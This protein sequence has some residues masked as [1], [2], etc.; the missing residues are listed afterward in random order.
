MS[1]HSTRLGLNWAACYVVVGAL[2]TLAPGVQAAVIVDDSW[3]DGG[4]NNGADPLDSNWWHSS[5]SNGIEVSTG[6]LG[7][8]TGTAGRG[9]HT[10]FP[11]QTLANAGDKLIA[12]YTFTT[13]QT[14]GSGG[15][16]FRV[17]L[18]DTLSRAGLDG[19]I[20]ASSGSPNSL[21][22]YHGTNTPGL[23][24]YMMDMDVRTSGTE[25]LNFR[26]HG[27]AVVAGSTPTGRLMGTTTGFTSISPS[28]PDG[29]YA[30][31]PNT[32]YTGSLTITRSSATEMELTGT[33]GAANHTVTATF[34][35]ADIG[36]LAFWA[37]SNIFGNSSSPN[38]PNNGI[39]FSNV[40]IEFI[41]IPEPSAVILGL[42]GIAAMVSAQRRRF[43]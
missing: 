13:P 4:R 10:V 8:V 36:M 7:M 33:L 12:T 11:T 30:F 9:I 37:N 28:G 32:T 24:G 3:A 42:L 34:D 18:F 15:S 29:A 1:C 6:S 25:D 17:G 22:G 21:Y 35:S 20:T 27:T 40:T 26:Q 31:F 43:Q 38:T 41:P 14:V 23:P 19:D 16:S 5:N 39:D 2:L